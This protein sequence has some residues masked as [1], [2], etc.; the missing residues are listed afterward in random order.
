MTDILPVFAGMVPEI[1]DAFKVLGDSPRIRGDGPLE[2]V[3]HS[4]QIGILP[5]FAGMVPPPR[6]FPVPHLNSPR[7][8]GDGPSSIITSMLFKSFS[9]Y[10]R[11]WS[12]KVFNYRQA[13]YILPV[14]AGMVR[15]KVAHPAGY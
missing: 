1:A 5:V 2:N 15:Q 9:P 11:G 3:F 12:L 7:I 13:A 4:G 8:R 6:H 10:S 14:F